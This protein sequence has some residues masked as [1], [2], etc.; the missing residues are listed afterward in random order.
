MVSIQDLHCTTLFPPIFHNVS[1]AFNAEHD[2][3][4]MPP[5]YLLT[6]LLD[7]FAFPV[8]IYHARASMCLFGFFFVFFFL[9]CGS[10][11]LYIAKEGARSHNV[12]VLIKGN[13]VEYILNEFCLS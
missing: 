7:K 12:A 9:H 11:T 5:T 13:E 4:V 8:P 1:M 2:I 6:S 3:G 10:V